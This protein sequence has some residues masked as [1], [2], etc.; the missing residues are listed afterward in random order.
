MA[1][2]DIGIS[3]LSAAQKALEVIGNNI[4]NAATEGYHKQRVELNPAFFAEKGEI[5]IGGGVDYE[6]TTRMISFLLDQEI[7]AQTS[8]LTQLD[9]EQN[10]LLTVESIFGELSE[11]GGLNSSF[12]DF[13]NALQDLTA[14]PAE[15]TWLSEVVSKASAL[16]I[17]FRNIGNYLSNLQTQ[18]SLETDDL[19]DQANAITL[20][21]SELNDKIE[22]IEISGEK[23]NN[24]KDQRDKLISDLS[25][26]ATVSTYSREFGVTDVSIGGI[27]VVAGTANLQ[28]E[29]GQNAGGD[30]GIGVAGTYTYNSSIVGGKLGGLLNL[31][32]ET[33]SDL[34]T[35][36][37][38]LASAVIEQVNDAHVQAVGASGSFTELTGVSLASEN[39]SEF[40]PAVT[41]GTI[42]VRVTNTTTGAITRHTIAVDASSDTLSTIAA[43]FSGITGL[44]ASVT[45]SQLYIQSTTG[46]K[47]DF[48]PAVLPD[49]TAE[50]LT[51]TSAPD[52]AVAGI[53]T[54][55]SNDTFTCT[56]AGNGDVGNG[57]LN[58]EV[59]NGAG[60]LIKTVNIGSGY[61]AGDDIELVDGVKITMSV[62]DVNNGDSFEIDVFN[63]TDSSGFLASAGM[64]TFFLGSSAIDIDVREYLKNDPN[65]FAIS[66]GPEMNDNT[67]AMNL[68]E[69]REIEISDLGDMTMQEY[70]T[71]IVVDTGR[72]IELIQLSSESVEVILQDMKNQQ[73]EISGVDI[74]EEAAN[75]LVFQ[76]MFQAM[77]K[78]M[79]IL[80][81][82]LNTLIGIV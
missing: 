37:D 27:P 77:S 75:M 49:P 78:Y 64:N 29:A 22:A 12:D 45:S 59:R 57:T 35:R 66:V 62:G 61:A 21:I 46:Y 73:S 1:N 51:G 81:E 7:L 41:D 15:T 71:Q 40:S 6:G 53:Y 18:M 56:V 44:S 42:Y 3:G 67:N 72:E 48:I 33:I 17:K 38:S 32:N 70:Y 4:A 76:Q 30:F 58:V 74:N 52:I 43:D 79:N 20:K 25:A 19:V 2:F 47:F 24:L 11:V 28:I 5:L 9:T 60:T 69:L 31:Q 68:Y 80:Q 23:A 34:Q 82:T 26:M 14:N 10:V 63:D 50:T 13:F 16:S 54:G 8:I 65:K 55:S 39:V 36:L